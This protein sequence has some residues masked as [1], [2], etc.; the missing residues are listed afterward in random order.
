MIKKLTA[1]MERHPVKTAVIS[2]SL[3]VLGTAEGVGWAQNHTDDLPADYCASP[4]A[5]SE[6]YV[7]PST[8][9]WQAKTGFFTSG[10]VAKATLP[11]DAYG[12]RVGF[13]APGEKG[14]P[15]LSQMMITPDKQGHVAGKLAA[16]DG[17]V[18]FEGQIIAQ[19]GSAACNSV[20]DITFES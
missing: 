5:G 8:F 16:A 3:L 7:A 20:P 15:N 13:H 19:E 2:T 12:M 11:P 4:F 10:V 17:L 1:A 18:Q 6:T 14:H 9:V